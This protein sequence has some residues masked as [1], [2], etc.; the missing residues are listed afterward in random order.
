MSTNYVCIYEVPK[1]HG[2]PCQGYRPAAQIHVAELL[3]SHHFTG[4]NPKFQ[5]KLPQP[6]FP[7]FSQPSKCISNSK[8]RPRRPRG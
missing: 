2:Q 6:V 3:L 4:P 7:L 1:T 8:F 5:P